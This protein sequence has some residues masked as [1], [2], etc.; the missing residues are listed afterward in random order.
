MFFKTIARP[1]L[2]EPAIVY[3]ILLCNS[4]INMTRR[5]R[6]VKVGIIRKKEGNSVTNKF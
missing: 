6:L 5:N 2:N 1:M 4:N 3:C